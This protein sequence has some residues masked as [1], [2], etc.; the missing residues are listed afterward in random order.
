MIKTAYFKKTRDTDIREAFL[1]LLEQDSL[2]SPNFVLSEFPIADCCARVD[3]AVF[4]QISHGYEFKSDMDNLKRLYDQRDAY[5][6]FFD[7]VTLVVGR[8]HVLDALEII[9][10]WWGVTLAK[11]SGGKISFLQLRSARQN[12]NQDLNIIVKQLWKSEALALLSNRGLSNKNK[13]AICEIVTSR[14]PPEEL[15]TIVNKRIIY[16]YKYALSDLS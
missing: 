1:D 6:A 2:N 10:D 13:S 14:F 5:N 4:G 3:V 7:K 15:K 9:P 8:T 12:P 11:Y 16:R